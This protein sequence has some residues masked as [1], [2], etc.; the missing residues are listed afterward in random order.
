MLFIAASVI[1]FL[2]FNSV[3]PALK[4]EASVDLSKLPPCWMMSNV[5]VSSP[6]MAADPK[7]NYSVFAKEK[8]VCFDGLLCVVSQ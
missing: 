8:P 2:L 6:S 3:N 4:E 5:P 1:L 7:Y